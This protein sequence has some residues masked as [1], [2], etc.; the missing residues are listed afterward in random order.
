[1]VPTLHEECIACRL[2][3]GELSAPGGPILRNHLW[4]LEHIIEPIPMAGWLVLKPV[5]HVESFAELTLEEAS[6]FGP[7]T[8]RITM[9][10]TE[11]IRPAKIYLSMYMEGANA[12]HLH[13]HLI[14][15]MENTPSER[16]GPWIFEYARESSATLKNLGDVAFATQ[17]ASSVRLLLN[18]S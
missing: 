7:L 16:R 1:L 18:Q 10:M 13:V 8:R 5:R 12:A 3:K 2:H 11:V 17:I 15:R 14:P 4:V 9:A 6:S